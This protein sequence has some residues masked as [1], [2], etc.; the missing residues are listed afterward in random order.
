MHE[1]AICQALIDKAESIARS[2]HA[3]VTRLRVAIGPLSGVEPQLLRQAYTLASA[4]T[5]ADGADL[6]IEDTPVRVRCRSCNTET[7]A[8]ANRLI[9]GACGD[10]RTELV[11]GDEM[12]LLQ[13][14]LSADAPVFEAQDV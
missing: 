1:L 5:I 14:E 4:G 9:C 6:V 3:H 12:M 8:S 10:W 7:A 11:S 2:R 13:L